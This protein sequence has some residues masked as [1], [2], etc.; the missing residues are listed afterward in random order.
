MDSSRRK[1]EDAPR[2]STDLSKAN[3]RASLE[4]NG[5]RPLLNGDSASNAETT[6]IASSVK[7]TPKIYVGPEDLKNYGMYRHL[8]SP[9]PRN[10]ANDAQNP[11]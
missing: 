8:L 1:S 2:P 4:T 6:S 9:S 7:E 11:V 3:G 10:R 5:S